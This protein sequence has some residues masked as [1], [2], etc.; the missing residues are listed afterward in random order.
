MSE[1][2]DATHVG[3]LATSIDR[4]LAEMAE[5]NAVFEDVTRDAV[6]MGDEPRWYVR[7]RGE[8]KEHVTVWL[9]LG[10]RT[11][12]YEAYVMPAPLDNVA[13]VYE[14]VLR[15]NQRLIGAHFAIGV[16]DAIFLRGDVPLAALH[17]EELDRIVGS[18]YQ[19]VDAHFPALIRLGMA[20]H[21]G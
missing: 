6:S 1:L 18:L 3:D 20:R 5:G 10:Q 7:L 21:F 11:M 15:L 4:W 13:A 16:E 9:T 2:F 14:M 17:A 12:R 8:A 19:Y